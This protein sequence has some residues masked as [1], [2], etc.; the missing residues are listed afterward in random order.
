MDYYYDYFFLLLLLLL[1][2]LLFFFFLLLLLLSSLLTF[3][4]N[5]SAYN[6]LKIFIDIFHLLLYNISVSCSPMMKLRL[7]THYM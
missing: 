7:L 5:L 3:V 6:C 4:I 1:L 2:L